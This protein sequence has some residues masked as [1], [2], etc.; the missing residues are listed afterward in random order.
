MSRR[1]VTSAINGRP[2]MARLVVA[3]DPIEQ[4]DPPRFELVASRTIDRLVCGDVVR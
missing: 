2:V 4:D 3:L 1:M